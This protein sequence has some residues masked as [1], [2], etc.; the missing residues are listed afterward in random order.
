MESVN[1]QKA[2]Q[3]S[4]SQTD[5]TAVFSNFD[6]LLKLGNQNN[7]FFVFFVVPAL[8]RPSTRWFVQHFQAFHAV[9]AVD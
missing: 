8:P 6:D 4:S 5:N 3:L 7:S 1:L 9:S 2:E